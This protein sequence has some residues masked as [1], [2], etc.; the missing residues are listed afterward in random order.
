MLA[1]RGRRIRF[2]AIGPVPEH[3]EASSIPHHRIERREQPHAVDLMIRQRFARGPIPGVPVDDR[4]GKTQLRALNSAFD[5]GVPVRRRVAQPH[6]DERE[7][8]VGTGA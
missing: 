8:R 7:A 3:F 2:E 5:L 4:M 6:D 1:L